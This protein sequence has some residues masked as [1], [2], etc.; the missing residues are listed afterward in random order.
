MY[1]AGDTA[2]TTTMGG[3]YTAGGVGVITKHRYNLAH[4]K[5]KHTHKQYSRGCSCGEESC[6]GYKKQ[7]AQNGFGNFRQLSQY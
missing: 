5:Y 6:A 1:N 4:G 3:R 2:N 7:K